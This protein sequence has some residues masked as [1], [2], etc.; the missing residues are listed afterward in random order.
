MRCGHIRQHASTA[1]R[2]EASDNN[3]NAAA[4][5]PT[6]ST[7]SHPHVSR[8]DALQPFLLGDDG[9]DFG[10]DDEAAS[11]TLAQLLNEVHASFAKLADPFASAGDTDDL[12]MRGAR[13][14]SVTRDHDLLRNAQL[15]CTP[16]SVADATTG[17]DATSCASDD[18][19]A[20]PRSAQGGGD[21][22]CE[23]AV[24]TLASRVSLSELTTTGADAPRAA[25]ADAM[26]VSQ[27]NLT[28]TAAAV[29]HGMDA[30]NDVRDVINMV[31]D[32]NR[33]DGD[34]DAMW[35][36]DAR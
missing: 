17:A 10:D 28:H 14:P 16:S 36:R 9:V 19:H 26:T 8:H 29:G 12:L 18:A 1:R 20:A 27:S 4:A 5:S 31:M 2:M 35:G 15:R 6:S 21:G 11:A 13:S 25:V 22:A 7:L 32:N 30:T 34:D 23:N 33:T 24:R 3:G